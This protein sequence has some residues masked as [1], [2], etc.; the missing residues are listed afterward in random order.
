MNI[1]EVALEV[2]IQLNN[3]TVKKFMCPIVCLD[4]IMKQYNT[5]N[6]GYKLTFTDTRSFNPHIKVI[7]SKLFSDPSF[8]TMF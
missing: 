3:H 1:D 8:L 6:S 5:P 7:D 4:M 2:E